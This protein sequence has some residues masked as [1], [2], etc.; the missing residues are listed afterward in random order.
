[1]EQTTIIMA[2]SALGTISAI[3]LGW[4]GQN[5]IVRQN[6]RNDAGNDAAL[7]T[8]VDYIKRG[9]D[10]MRLE[11]RVQG[12]RFEQ[13]AER[14]TRVEESAKQAHLRLDRSEKPN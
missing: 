14:V 7:K 2:L 1:M 3:L 12:Q 5:R 13:L 8:D 11:Q 10:D 4:I 6:T 9:V